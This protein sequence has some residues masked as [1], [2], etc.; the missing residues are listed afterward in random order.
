[1]TIIEIENTFA[2]FS[3]QLQSLK[4]QYSNK[5]MTDKIADLIRETQVT[6]LQVMR[7]NSENEKDNPELKQS[8]SYHINDL[9]QQIILLKQS[10]EAATFEA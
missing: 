1:M 7:L 3:S 10:F 4:A 8:V 5:A 2:E 6:K 9:H